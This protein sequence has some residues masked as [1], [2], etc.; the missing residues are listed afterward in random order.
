M[1]TIFK[2]LISVLLMNGIVHATEVNVFDFTELELSQLEVR[3]VRGADNLT[4]NLE[5]RMFKL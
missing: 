1:K 2:F 4:I 5:F 3:K